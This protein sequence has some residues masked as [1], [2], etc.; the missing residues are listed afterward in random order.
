MYIADWGVARVS[1]DGLRLEPDSGVVW[2]VS[3]GEQQEAGGATLLYAALAFAG[4]AGLTVVTAGIGPSRSTGIV[5]GMLAGIGAALVLGTFAM[6]VASPVLRLPWHAP[7]RVLATMVMGEDAIA[8]ILEFE[9]ASFFTGVAVVAVI[10]ILLG[11]LY[12]AFAQAGP[13]RLV[14]GGLFYALAVWVALQYFLLPAF[15]PLVIDKGFPPLWYGLTFG[16]FGL[17]L[18]LFFALAARRRPSA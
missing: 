16:V 2:R 8:N 3:R 11:A 9:P 17:A 18:G 14:L 7:P 13:V 10:G 1:V 12:A 4:L 5:Q 15:F 6:F